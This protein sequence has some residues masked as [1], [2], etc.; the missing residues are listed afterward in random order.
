MPAVSTIIALTALA[1]TAVGTGVAIHNAN[2]QKK[3]AQ[4]LA[5][6]QNAKEAAREKELEDEQ[7]QSDADAAG[8]S[9]RAIARKAQRDKA[10][11]AQGRAGTV[12]ST[13]GSGP[14]DAPLGSSGSPSIP[15]KTLLGL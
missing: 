10:I 12:L 1:A 5:D 8:A 3:D 7:R 15:T 2:E 13:P 4:K 9:S 14:S 6:D 11:T